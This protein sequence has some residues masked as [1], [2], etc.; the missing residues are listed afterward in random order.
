VNNEQW[1]E[2]EKRRE[3]KLFSF[4]FSNFSFVWGWVMKRRTPEER[5]REKIRK[6]ETILE[7]FAEHEIQWAG[8][9]MLWYRV[10]RKEMPDDVY[11]AC[12]FFRNKEFLSKPGSLTLL[13][14]MYRQCVREFPEFTKEMAFDLLAYRFKLYA[15]TLR[16]G[17]YYG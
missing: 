10:K 11:R 7:E 12:V 8:D 2:G 17:G 16:T 9:L 6:Q 5:Y 3:R 1:E 4:F 13:Y 15:K 14:S